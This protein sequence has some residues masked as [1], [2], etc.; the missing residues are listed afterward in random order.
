M[1]ELRKNPELYR[2]V[3]RNRGLDPLI[4]EFD[5]GLELYV[6]YADA[7]RIG[8]ELRALAKQNAKGAA[9][10]R[11]EGT[12]LKEQL[13]AHEPKERALAQELRA[14]EVKLP[15]FIHP[16]VP[17]GAGDELEKTIDFGGIPVVNASMAAEFMAANPQIRFRPTQLKPFHHHTMV[18]Q[19]VDEER[20]ARVAGKRFYYELGELAILDLALLNYAVGFFRARGYDH[21]MVP[22]FAMRR[23]VEEEITYLEAFIDTIFGVEQDG[24]ILTPTAE[25]PVLAYYAG[26]TLNLPLRVTAWGPCF[27]RENGAHGKDTRGIFRVKQFQKVELQCMVPEG[28]DFAEVDRIR[29]DVQAFMQ[30]LGIPWRTVIVPA[31]DMDKRALYQV[32]V[33]AWFPGQGKYRETQSIATCGD[34][35]AE[36][37]GINYRDGNKKKPVQNVYGTAVAVQRMLCALV[38]NHYCHERKAVIV[39]DCLRPFTMGVTEVPM[40]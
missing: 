20:A 4:A 13:A 30:A 37:L 10:N 27:R 32:D 22:P 15:N 24:L 16:D 18:G 12:R 25:H 14:L 5:Q 26:D 39:P 7:V 2:Q 33:Q 8:G 34:W 19:Y 9:D 38:E 21:L 3:L 35:V 31:A 6:Q 1:R 40:G 28:D 23:D 17:I 29:L 36:K 11:E